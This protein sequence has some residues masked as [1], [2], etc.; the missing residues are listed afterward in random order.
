MLELLFLNSA[1]LSPGWARIRMVSARAADEEAASVGGL[2]HICSTQRRLGA[3][4]LT[5]RANGITTDPA[6]AGPFGGH[7]SLL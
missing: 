6:R 1:C 2:F 3:V 4:P 5:P 7:R